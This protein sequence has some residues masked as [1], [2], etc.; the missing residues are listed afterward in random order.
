MFYGCK[1]TTN[2]ADCQ[3]IDPFFHNT[4]SVIDHF[5]ENLQTTTVFVQTMSAFVQ[6]TTTFVQTTT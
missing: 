2:R 1:G 6:T 5:F 3:T 4:F